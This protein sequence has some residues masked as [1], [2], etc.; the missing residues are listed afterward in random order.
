MTFRL[1]CS[2]GRDYAEVP[3]Q[4]PEGPFQDDKVRGEESR[5]AAA[6][7]QRRRSAQDVVHNLKLCSLLIES[8][9][10]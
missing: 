5:A 1:L 10:Q 7:G 4:P 3:Q 6:F 2:G 8:G 9:K